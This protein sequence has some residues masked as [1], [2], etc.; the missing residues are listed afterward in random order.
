VCDGD[1]DCSGGRCID[2]S[3]YVRYPSDDRKFE[4]WDYS[5]T[6][7]EKEYG[8]N[9]PDGVTPADGTCN[10]T[11]TCSDSKE[12]YVVTEDAGPYI[13]NGATCWVGNCNK[14]VEAEPT[15][16][17][18]Y[19]G[20]TQRDINPRP[21]Q[22]IPFENLE[23]Y[24]IQSTAPAKNLL[25]RS[26]TCTEA[27]D[28]PSCT[29]EEPPKDLDTDKRLCDA[30]LNAK[31]APRINAAPGTETTY[32]AGR[33][34]NLKCCGDDK[35]E[36]GWPYG[37]TAKSTSGNANKGKY[38]ATETVCDDYTGAD[39]GDINGWIDNNCNGK[40]NCE[41]S[42]CYST[43]QPGPN[44]GPCCHLASDCVDVLHEANDDFIECGSEDAPLE[45]DCKPANSNL[46]FLTDGTTYRPAI[47]YPGPQGV[48]L[49]LASSDEVLIADR[50]VRI[51]LGGLSGAN[52]QID[53][54]AENV[55]SGE[56]CSVSDAIVKTVW[57]ND[58][59]P[60]AGPPYSTTGFFYVALQNR[61]TKDCIVTI[62]IS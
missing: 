26:Y 15:D 17:G 2:K 57:N 52:R 9:R 47:T 3:C 59:V 8:L 43:D 48:K 31:L 13:L 18:N 56:E 25:S 34:A 41:D 5:D 44:G 28:L 58:R 29:K 21:I 12:S 11:P 55:G 33:S 23:D 30:C 37:A 6:T 50:H 53:V 60:L 46:A 42:N 16:C 1:E 49:C 4:C 7:F 38:F 62:T 51:N 19:N 24:C 45:C 54:T 35:G 27:G 36:G 39:A 32:S 40:K 10:P 20:K 14:P 22:E 61:A